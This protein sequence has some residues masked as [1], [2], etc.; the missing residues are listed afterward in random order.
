MVAT[1]PVEVLSIRVSALV[2]CLPAGSA[3]SIQRRI[4]LQR[5]RVAAGDTSS[6]VR[7][8]PF[9]FRK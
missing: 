1:Q 2:A 3:E 9:R 4:G 6:Q 5:A 8:R 7:H